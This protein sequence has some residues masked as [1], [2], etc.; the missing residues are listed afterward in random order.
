MVEKIRDYEIWKEYIEF[1]KNLIEK[2]LSTGKYAVN[3]YVDFYVKSSEDSMDK[4]DF[5]ICA[6][7][8]FKV[9]E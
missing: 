4:E 1:M 9:S 7:T 6:Q 5:K 3:E 8:N 2:G